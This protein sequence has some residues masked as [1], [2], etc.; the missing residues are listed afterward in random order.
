MG[1]YWR[2]LIGSGRDDLH[3]DLG[4]LRAKI[5]LIWHSALHLHYLCYFAVYHLE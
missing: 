4:D 2:A 5:S 1:I 3:F